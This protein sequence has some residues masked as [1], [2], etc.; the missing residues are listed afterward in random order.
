M[1]SIGPIIDAAVPALNAVFSNDTKS[2]PAVANGPT[3]PHDPQPAQ[4]G[5]DQRTVLDF[6]VVKD[7]VSSLQQQ[8]Q[9]FVTDFN[10]K[11][12]QSLNNMQKKLEDLDSNFRD[13][14]VKATKH[15]Y[16]IERQGELTNAM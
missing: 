14:V 13:S 8:V 4:A 12:D 15:Q 9:H 7:E 3:D 16:Y 6:H 2:E 10:A 11:A 1:L 5:L